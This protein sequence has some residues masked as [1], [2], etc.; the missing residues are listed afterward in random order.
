MVN[1][2]NENFPFNDAADKCLIL[3]DEGRISC[4][5]VEACKAILGGMPVRVDQKCK[6]STALRPTP[7][8]VTSNGDMTIVRDGN[9]ST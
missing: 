2:T 5:I 1:W 9:T 7:V 6:G 8:L 3:W 4:K